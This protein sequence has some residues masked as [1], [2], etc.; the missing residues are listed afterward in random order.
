MKKFSILFALVFILSFTGNIFAAANSSST[1][2]SPTGMTQSYAQGRERIM[3]V[4]DHGRR[5]RGRY[6]HRR[7]ARRERRELRRLARRP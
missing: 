3:I 1:G 4:R 6:R 7:W 2:A 5:D